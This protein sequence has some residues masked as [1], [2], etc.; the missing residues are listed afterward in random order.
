MDPEVTET[1]TEP[2][3]ESINSTIS[4]PLGDATRTVEVNPTTGEPLGGITELDWL[5]IKQTLSDIRENTTLN[6]VDPVTNPSGMS[7]T[8][9]QGQAILD[10]MQTIE[11]LA[12]AVVVTVLLVFVSKWLYNLLGGTFFGGL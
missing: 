11:H 10:T 5:E 1:T 3:T 9:E 2:F 4:T 7:M 12:F 8:F 6:E